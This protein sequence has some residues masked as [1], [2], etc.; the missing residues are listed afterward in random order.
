VAALLGFS[1]GLGQAAE[2][3][4]V[5]IAYASQTGHTEKMAAAAAAGVRQAEAEA[6]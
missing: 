1:A 3:V 6:V 2:P 5:L 4:K